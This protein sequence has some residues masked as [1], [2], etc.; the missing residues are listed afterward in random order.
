MQSESA[1]TLSESRYYFGLLLACVVASDNG[2]SA[3]CMALGEKE[4]GYKSARQKGSGRRR[5]SLRLTA[6]PCLHV[7]VVRTLPAF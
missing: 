2:L 3:M 6:S 7:F 5:L 4:I 1:V